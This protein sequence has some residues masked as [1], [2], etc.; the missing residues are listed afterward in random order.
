MAAVIVFD[1][2]IPF[3]VTVNPAKSASF[4]AKW[5]LLGLKTIPLAAQRSR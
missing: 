5:N 2:L 3:A 4:P 1:G